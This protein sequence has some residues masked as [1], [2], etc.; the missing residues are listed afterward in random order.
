MIEWPDLRL[1]PVNLW[2]LPWW[3]G[4][5]EEQNGRTSRSKRDKEANEQVELVSRLYQAHKTG[6]SFRG[7]GDTD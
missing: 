2:S 3:V 7:K 4:G 1:P 6:G 5:T